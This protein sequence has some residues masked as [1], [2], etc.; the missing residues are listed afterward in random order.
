M[1]WDKA[2]KYLD[3]VIENYREIGPAGRMA[4]VFALLPL[5]YRYDNGERTEALYKEIMETG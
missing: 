4:L 2:K 5:K 3:S 1:D